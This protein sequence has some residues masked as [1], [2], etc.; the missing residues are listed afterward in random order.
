M[1][2]DEEAQNTSIELLQQWNRI[3]MYIPFSKYNRFM[4]Q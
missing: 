1:A 2:R 3:V 4:K